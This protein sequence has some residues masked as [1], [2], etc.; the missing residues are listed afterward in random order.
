LMPDPNTALTTK[1]VASPIEEF[2]DKLAYREEIRN[3]ILQNGL[4]DAHDLHGNTLYRLNFDTTVIPANDTSAWAMIEVNVAPPK[5]NAEPTPEQFAE[6]VNKKIEFESQSVQDAITTSGCASI[7]V[8]DKRSEK[9]LKLTACMN[10]VGY[11]NFSY[12]FP[13]MINSETIPYG[14]MLT[15]GIKNQKSPSQLNQLQVER[16]VEAILKYEETLKS[17]TKEDS[18]CSFAILAGNFVAEYL[19][20]QLTHKPQAIFFDFVA[21]ELKPN[22]QDTTQARLQGFK[23]NGK[24]H[25]IAVSDVKK[26][27]DTVFKEL[28]FVSKNELLTDIRK[29]EIR[30]EHIS[31]LGATPK[32]T[33]QRI[34]DVAARRQATELALA[35]N[36]VTGGANMNTALSYINQNDGYFHAL[37]RQPLVVGY[38]DTDAFGWLI[39]PKYDIKNTSSRG[40]QVGY[41]HVPIQNGVSGMISVPV[42]WNSVQLNIHKYWQPE[43]GTPR[44]KADFTADKYETITGTLNQSLPSRYLLAFDLFKGRYPAL[45]D[46]MQR[47]AVYTVTEKES[48]SITLLGENLWRSVAVLMGG[49]E[50]DKVTVLPDMKGIV[51]QFDKVKYPGLVKKDADMPVVQLIVVTAEGAV[52]AGS[53]KIQKAKAPPEKKAT[54]KWEILGNAFFSPGGSLSLK[55]D[56]SIANGFAKLEFKLLN[57]S[58]ESDM[59]DLLSTPSGIVFDS[60]TFVV[61]IPVDNKSFMKLEN[62]LEY[63]VHVTIYKTPTDSKPTS[64]VIGSIVKYKDTDAAK[65]SYAINSSKAGVDLTFPDNYSIAYPALNNDNPVSVKISYKYKAKPDD[66]ESVDI[67]EPLSCTFKDKK[68][69]KQCL[70]KTKNLIESV[71]TIII[72]DGGNDYPGAKIK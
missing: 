14:F 61:F 2:R 67:T 29:M 19:A 72:G 63:K 23:F 42:F 48:A 34:S 24:S 6:I 46:K 57:S 30:K 70:L 1:A 25:G 7:P 9:K 4:D 10:K 20:K 37:K 28:Y 38:T 50:A 71:T 12:D 35:L 51:V 26:A 69:D 36:A 5:E 41:R 27:E 58:A 62:G 39:G 54:D 64:I 21:G 33:V 16:I 47:D 68:K 65:V 22:S 8:K 44:V 43:D 40:S 45:D 56:S 66:K 60:K 13:E 3:E 59:T 18:N 52:N 49:Q 55:P 17:C 32:E 31:F 11:E 53:V 15:Q